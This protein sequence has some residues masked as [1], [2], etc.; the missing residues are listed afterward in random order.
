MEFIVI[1]VVV[2]VSSVL[3]VEWLPVTR[4]DNNDAGRPLCEKETKHIPSETMAL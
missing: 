2:V 1:V 4:S 3:A